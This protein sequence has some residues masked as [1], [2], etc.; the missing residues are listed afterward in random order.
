MS[1]KIDKVDRLERERLFIERLKNLKTD[2][3][4]E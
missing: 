2:K 4:P 1:L 3:N